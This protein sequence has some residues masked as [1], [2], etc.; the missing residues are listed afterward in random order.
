M[1]PFGRSYR[2]EIHME[3][4]AGKSTADEKADNCQ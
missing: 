2:K 1:V 3:E 4:S